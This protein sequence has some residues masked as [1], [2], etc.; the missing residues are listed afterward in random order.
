MES[1]RMTTQRWPSFRSLAT[2]TA[3]AMAVPELPPRRATSKII[4]LKS[5]IKKLFSTCVITGYRKC[6]VLF[7][8]LIVKPKDFYQVSI[9]VSL[10][11]SRPSSLISM[12]DM[13]KD[14]SSFDLY[15][16]SMTW[17]NKSHV[18][19]RG[20]NLQKQKERIQNSRI[21]RARSGW[22]RTRCPPP[23]TGSYQ[24]CW[25]LQAQPGWSLQ[26]RHQQSAHSTPFMESHWPTHRNS[27]LI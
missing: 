6:F 19:V 26:G 3:A 27:N 2:F 23:H 12:R 24:S 13:L 20:N 4:Q 11:H 1:G 7:F 18:T 17:Q 8:F 22:S 10:P 21:C 9:C 16:V 15:H 25:A 5:N 14:S